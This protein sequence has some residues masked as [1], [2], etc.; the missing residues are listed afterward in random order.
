MKQPMSDETK[1]KLTYSGELLVFAILFLVLGILRLTKVM[2][3]NDT[4]RLIFNYITLAGG[5]WG[6]IDFTWA[7][8]SPKKRKR[9]SMIDKILMI[10]ASITLIVLDIWCLM[11]A[12]DSESFKNTFVLVVSILFFYFTISFTFQAIYHFYK[13]VPLLLEAIKE[14]EEEK[15]NKDASNNE[16]QIK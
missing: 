7:L 10:P 8:I 11:N 5:I 12:S 1:A 15:A 14:E 13:P 9:S 3:Y 4:R 6:V 16:E 2:G